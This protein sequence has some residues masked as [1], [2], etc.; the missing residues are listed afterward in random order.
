MHD[1]TFGSNLL[2]IARAGAGTNN[3]P[4]DR[5]AE[6]GICVFN[7]PGAN[8]NAVKELVLTGLLL[9][10]RKIPQAIAWAHSLEHEEGIAKLVEKGKSQF[11][12]PEI[13]GKTLG[14]IGLGAIGALVANAAIALGM[15]VV[16]TDPFLSV[17][18]ALRLNPAVKIVKDSDGVFAAADYL[19]I[20]VPFNNDT[21]GMINA[22]TIAKMKDGVL[23]INTSRGPLI[24]EEDLAAALQSGKVAG[25]GLDVL[26]VEPARMDNPLLKEEN[27]LVTPHI[28]W[29]PK[30]SR[31]RLM[32]IAVENLKAF[33][34]GAPQNVV[35]A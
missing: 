11:A 26:A 31:Q 6:E 27:C 18:A 3:I 30:E 13:K 32:D 28:A 2:A 10:S 24:V 5:C 14:I 33:L 7:T 25:A 15:Q 4:V 17:G 20:H 22:E 35:N 8:A 12:G 9:S 16:G 29:A 23:L 34:A 21:K 1:M 19:T